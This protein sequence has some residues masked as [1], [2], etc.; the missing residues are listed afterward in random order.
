MLIAHYFPTE[1]AMKA[2]KK[3]LIVN[4]LGD[5]GLLFGIALTQ[6]RFGTLGFVELENEALSHPD[7]ITAGLGFLLVCGFLA[8]SAQFPL[9]VWLPDA[10]A[11][12]TP[13]SALIHAATM[14]AAGIYLLVRIDFLLLPNVSSL[15]ALLGAA[16]AV[17]A[18]FCAVTQRDIKKVLAYSTLSQLGYMAATAGLGMM[19]LALFHLATHAFFKALLFLGAGSVILGCHHEQ[20]IFKMGGLRRRMPWTAWTFLI[21]VMAI[22]GVTFTSGFFSK[23]AILLAAYDSNSVVFFMLMGGALLTAFYM[24]R[25][26]WL[27][28]HGEPRS[29]EAEHATECEPVVVIPLVILCIFAAIAGFSSLWP[30]QLGEI[31]FAELAA[32]H[33]SQGN[34]LVMTFGTL[35][36]I[37]GFWGS[38][39]LYRNVKDQD[40]LSEKAPTFFRLCESRLFFDEFYDW[41]IARPLRRIASIFEVMELLFI[42]GLM[43]RGLAGVTALLGFTA[44]AVH[45]G[46][47]R[48]YAIWFVGGLLFLIACAR[49]WLN[50]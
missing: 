38:W 44:S 13:V 43:A 41:C 46:G 30:V 42:S 1:D 20:D 7:L 18:G 16:M 31:F 39:N 26:Q 19:G 15:I 17:Y 2:S 9:Q 11:G 48:Q 10:M 23:D 36:W 32:V 14:V 6:A 22:S 47:V 49:G 5:I 40:P 3:A 21:G 45:R 29:K 50:Y 12:P 35:A 37:F 28:F 25:L 33:D 27:I 4:R 24:G 34:L 8:K